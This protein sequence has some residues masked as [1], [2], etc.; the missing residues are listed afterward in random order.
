MW[1]RALAAAG[2]CGF[3]GISLPSAEA[4]PRP[5]HNSFQDLPAPSSPQVA[6][7][8]P[9]GAGKTTNTNK[10]STPKAPAGKK[11]ASTA[12]HHYANTRKPRTLSPRV[13]R[14]RQAFVASASLRP[15]AQQLLQDR[16][17]PAYA[18]VEAYARAHAKE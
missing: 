14:M 9:A 13:R 7:Q 18:G 16:S 17:L 2:F 5:A 3:F 1:C 8:A 6:P 11:P 4:L 12:R 10:A 15:M